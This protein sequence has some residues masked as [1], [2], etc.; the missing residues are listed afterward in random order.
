VTK[1]GNGVADEKLIRLADAAALL[2]V[3]PMT[4]HNYLG[5]GILPSVKT[6]YGRGIPEAAVLKLAEERAIVAGEK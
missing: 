5:K 6:L 4:I 3:T 2:R 1:G